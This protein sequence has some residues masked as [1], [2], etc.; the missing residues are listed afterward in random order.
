MF[1]LTASSCG[2]PARNCNLV[3][4]QWLQNKS[5]RVITDASWYVPERVVKR[6][7]QIASVWEEIQRHS[8]N[9]ISRSSP[10]NYSPTE[11]LCEAWTASNLTTCW[12]DIGKSGVPALYVVSLYQ[13]VADRYLSDKRLLHWGYAVVHYILTTYYPQWVDCYYNLIIKNGINKI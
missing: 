1:G 11:E 4:L 2:V 6:D 3:T 9:Y 12:P 10:R 13:D 5:L 8:A 7:L